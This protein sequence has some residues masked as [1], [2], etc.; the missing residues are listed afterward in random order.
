MRELAF[1]YE[2]C[3]FAAALIRFLSLLLSFPLLSYLF[4]MMPY[5][6]PTWWDLQS[7]TLQR[8]TQSEP[9]E[10]YT[11][12]D[13]FG[14]PRRETYGPNSGYAIQVY[15]DQVHQVFFFFFW[16]G[17]EEEEEEEEEKKKKRRE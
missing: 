15:N 5:T 4:K 3:M 6:N 10:R 8:W 13:P 9:L 1:L 12:I 16:K 17:E 14:R 2:S 11:V 7:P